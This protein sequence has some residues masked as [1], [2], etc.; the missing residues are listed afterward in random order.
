MPPAN[1]RAVEGCNP[2]S[3]LIADEV[4][5]VGDYAFQEKC[6]ARMKE[7]MSGGTTVILV[8]HSIEQVRRLCNKATWLSHGDVVMTGATEEVCDAYTAEY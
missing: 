2:I 3:F 8:S 4:L 7:L 6:E 1:R 5:S